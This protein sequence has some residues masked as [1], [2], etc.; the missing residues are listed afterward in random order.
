VTAKT[1]GPDALEAELDALYRAPLSEFISRRDALARRL[2]TDGA[3]DQARRVKALRKPTAVAAAINRLHLESEGL[4]AL[5]AA[6]ASLRDALADPRSVEDRRNAIGRDAGSASGWPS[7]SGARAAR[8]RSAVGS[9]RV[10][11]ATSQGVHAHATIAGQCSQQASQR[12][13]GRSRRRRG[14]EEQPGGRSLAA[15]L[16]AGGLAFQD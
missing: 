5:E 12:H 1:A 3:A 16:R 13:R 7:R 10:E 14:Q 4:A 6:S 11:H 2:K 9:H 8:V 15:A